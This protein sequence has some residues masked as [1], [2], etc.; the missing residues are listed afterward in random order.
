M[1]IAIIGIAYQAQSEDEANGNCMRGYKVLS[2]RGLY[3][4]PSLCNCV[5]RITVIHIIYLI[6]MCSLMECIIIIEDLK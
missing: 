3:V 5:M 6:C 2:K 1:R 4:G